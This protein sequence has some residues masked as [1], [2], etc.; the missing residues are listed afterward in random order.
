LNLMISDGSDVKI[1]V[2]FIILIIL[3]IVVIIQNNRHSMPVP[4]EI[5]AE[6]KANRILVEK[7]IRRLSLLRDGIMI[8]SYRVALGGAPIG[9]KQQEGDNRTPEGIYK[10][11]R[12][13]EKSKFHLSLHISY[14]TPAEIEAAEQ[15]GVSPGGDIMVHG[16]PNGLGYIGSLHYQKDWT[17]GCIA[18]TDEEIEEIWNAVSDGTVIEIRP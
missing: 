7:S 12:R 15:R 8:K 3:L 11:D 9:N 1:K 13:N 5:K 2:L 10:I 17:A 4:E 14:P 6:I 18:V 16:L